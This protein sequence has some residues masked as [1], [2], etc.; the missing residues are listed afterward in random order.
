VT[1][2]GMLSAQFEHT[3]HVTD[4]GYEVLT[5]LDGRTKF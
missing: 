4:D 2:D 3:L 5:R 1:M